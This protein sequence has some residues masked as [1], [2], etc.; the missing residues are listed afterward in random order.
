MRTVIAAATCLFLVVVGCNKEDTDR[1]IKRTSEPGGRAGDDTFSLTVPALAT[2]VRQSQLQTVQVVV[3]RGAGFKQ[4]VKLEV[5]APA[6][7]SIDPASPR[8]EASE[9]PEVQLKVTAAEDASLG[10]HKVQ[11]RAVPDKGEATTAEF[12]VRVV[13]K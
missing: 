10:D 12:V 1:N 3:V 7:L 6:G 2:D 11:V 9:K 13:A 5:K 8:I 4:G